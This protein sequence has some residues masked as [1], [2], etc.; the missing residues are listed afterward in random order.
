MVQELEITSSTS[1]LMPG[2]LVHG[3][4]ISEAVECKQSSLTICKSVSPLPNFLHRCLC[5]R[6][7]TAEPTK[8]QPL[9]AKTW[10]WRRISGNFGG[11]SKCCV[12]GE[13]RRVGLPKGNEVDTMINCD[14]RTLNTIRGKL[15][16][17][18]A[19]GNVQLGIRLSKQYSLLPLLTDPPS[20][21]PYRE[22]WGNAQALCVSVGAELFAPP[23]GRGEVGPFCF[24]WAHFNSLVACLHSSATH[25]YIMVHAYLILH[26]SEIQGFGDS[27][28]HTTGLVHSYPRASNNQRRICSQRKWKASFLELKDLLMD[29]SA[30]W[31]EGERV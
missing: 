17:P 10:A 16:L 27:K 25:S 31:W 21:F 29:C 1:L 3:Q 4:N 13:G 14:C 9:V 19:K 23:L 18:T 5:P 2:M 8:R 6:K 20:L 15:N 22:P 30:L 7:V 24:Q 11:I 26:I 28:K 12:R